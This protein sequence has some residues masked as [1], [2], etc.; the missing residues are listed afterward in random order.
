[1]SLFRVL[2][3]K[4]LRR[5]WRN[6]ASWVIFLAIPLFVTGLVGFVFGP[7]SNTTP[8]GRVHFAIVDEDDTRLTRML[9]GALNQ[10][11]AGEHLDAIFLSRAEALRQVQDDKL[12]AMIV[13]PAGFTRSYLLSTNTV[14]LELVKDPAQSIHP[15]VIE[16]LL[17]VVVT[18]LDSIKRNFGPKLPDWQAVFEGKTDYHE[19]ARLID[20]AGDKLKSAEKF[21]DPPRIIYTRETNSPTVTAATSPT[22]SGAAPRKAP[23]PAYNIFGYL[24]PG[25]AAMFLLFLGENASRDVHREMEQQTL[26]RFRTL[27][28]RL[29]SFIASK[30]A[31][32]FVFLSASAAV[33][34]GGGGLAFHIAW[35]DPV[36]VILLTTGYCLFASGLMT[37]VPVLLGDQRNAQAF[38]NIIAMGLGLAGGSAFPAR[39]LPAFIR[40]YVTPVLPNSWKLTPSERSPWIPAGALDGRRPQNDGLRAGA[41]D[42]CR[43]AASTKSRARCRSMKAILLIGHND[44][45]VFLK[46]KA[47]FVWL[48]VVPVVFIGFMGYASRG[49]DKPAN[50]RPTVMVDNQDTNYLGAVLMEELGTQGMNVV[51]PSSSEE[52]PMK[53][54]NPR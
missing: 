4:D 41:H 43:G 16:E 6:P 36:A 19:V 51:S 25:M 26:Q 38:G 45:R 42:G 35:R 39:Q 53:I 46:H 15:A 22:G 48:F 44:L 28:H 17:G 5:A 20:R 32:C 18:A 50:A 49:P 52:A 23:E 29:H 47:S 8:L 12:S 30:F 37:L 40:N 33:M 31:F 1:M 2:L 21:L 24:L 27:H 7:K 9:R 54:R 11:Q 10:G 14:T 3:L 13:I 34:I